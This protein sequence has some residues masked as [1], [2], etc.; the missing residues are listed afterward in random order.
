MGTDHAIKMTKRSGIKL[1][2]SMIFGRNGPIESEMRDKIREI[3]RCTDYIFILA[4]HYFTIPLGFRK[5]I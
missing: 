3:S 4:S 2:S 5:I 1:K